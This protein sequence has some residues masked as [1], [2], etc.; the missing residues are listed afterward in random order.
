MHFRT[1]YFAERLDPV[2]MPVAWLSFEPNK[3]TVHLLDHP[4]L[5]K[6]STLVTYFRALN[7]SRMNRAYETAKASGGL[8]YSTIAENSLMTDKHSRDQLYHRL[9]TAT[10]RFNVLEIRRTDV[11]K[12]TFNSI[13]RRE[14]RELLRPL[15]VRLGQDDGDEGMD[16]GGVQQEFFR[17][18]VAE[19]VNP[20]YGKSWEAVVLIQETKAYRGIYY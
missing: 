12:D 8:M 16:S 1:E 19:A 10:T 15:K 14:E 9:E 4:Y 3:R 17:L 6:P 11:L 5:F 2:D 13:W 18:A 7:Y 20:D